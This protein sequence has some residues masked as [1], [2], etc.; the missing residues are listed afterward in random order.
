LPRRE[1]PL[2]T[3]SFGGRI[4]W[5]AGLFVV[6]TGGLSLAAAFGSRH[7]PPLF[8]LAALSPADVWRGEVWRLVTWPWVESGPI[9]LILAIVFLLW[10]G[11]DV[12][13]EMGSRPFLR[14]FGG[15]LL[16]AAVCTCLI[17]RIDGAVFE[18]RYLGTWPLAT[19]V[20]VAWG[21]WFPHRVVRIYFIIPVRGFWIAW[22]TVAITIVVAAYGGWESVLPEML[23]EGV[24]LGWIYQ[25]VLFARWKRWV[26]SLR[27]ERRKARRAPPRSAGHLRLVEPEDEDP[28]PLPPD[29]EEQV[30]GLL[31]GKRKPGEK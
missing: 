16:F 9:A 12:A 11:R 23:T 4:P 21:L 6:L 27:A 17:A 26:R 15:A 19:A 14:L 13:A 24:I 28:P 22:L 18:Q 3:L 8:E 2:E 29:V 30:H 1:S 7:G 31:G 5:A 20:L 10:F 25:D